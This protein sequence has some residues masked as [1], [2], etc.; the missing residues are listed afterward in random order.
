MEP[1][2]L[3][4][5][6][7]AAVEQRNGRALAALFTEDGVYHDVFYGSFVGHDRIAA[8]IDD[9][10]Y[11]DAA[12]FRWDMHDPVSD[13]RTLYAR[14]VFSYRSTLAGAEP[15]R[16]VFEGVAILR[17]RDGKIAEYHEITDTG[18]AFTRVGFAAERIVKLLR[19]Q[20]V[21]LRA[22]PEAARHI[23]D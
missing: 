20:D 16:V 4:A 6:L 8:L 22:R 12:D 15:G 5:T 3:L 9:W 23:A 17:L 19:R 21:A 2:H 1:Q 14:Y 13:G 11:R 10:F 18:P 7:T